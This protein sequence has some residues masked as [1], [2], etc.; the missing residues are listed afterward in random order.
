MQ[1]LQRDV[2]DSG[3]AYLNPNGNDATESRN[4]SVEVEMIA[5]KMFITEAPV[6]N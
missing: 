6:T 3:G 5:R 1:S 4:K 2:S